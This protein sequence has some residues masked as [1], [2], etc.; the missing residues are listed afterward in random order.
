MQLVREA[1]FA[2]PWGLA[3]VPM[4]YEPPAADPA[5]SGDI[6][7][8]NPAATEHPRAVGDAAAEL[9]VAVDHE[10]HGGAGGPGERD[11]GRESQHVRVTVTG[12]RAGDVDQ[13]QLLDRRRLAPGRAEDRRLC[14]QP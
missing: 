7:V 3:A 14:G 12:N 5:A 2:L 4:N 9:V 6:A 13:E 10:V 1:G 11:A 8:E